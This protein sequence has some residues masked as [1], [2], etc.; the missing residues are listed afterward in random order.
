[1]TKGG[2][3][4]RGREWE[5]GCRFFWAFKSVTAVCVGSLADRAIWYLGGR[6]KAM[7]GRARKKV[8]ERCQL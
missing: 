3:R 6:R 4:K 1:M 2:R 5:T 8:A 7:R